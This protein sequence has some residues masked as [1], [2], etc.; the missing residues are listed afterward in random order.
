MVMACA[1]AAPAGADTTTTVPDGV[2]LGGIPIGGLSADA[3]TA[4]VLQRYSRPVVL[5]VG[6]TVVNVSP[7]AL[8]VTV[9]ADTAVAKALTVP[10]DTTLGFRAVFSRARVAAYVAQ[11]AR[12]M[13]RPASNP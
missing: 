5:K 1:V 10:A 12:R 2:V 3:A 4:L 13:N 9:W 7:A 11:L 8:G 6:R